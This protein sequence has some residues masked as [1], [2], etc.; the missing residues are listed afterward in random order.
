MFES[1]T[2]FEM[3]PL[4][5]LSE[6][7]LGQSPEKI[8]LPAFQRNAVWSE[9]KV[10]ALWDSLLCRFPIGSILL[11]RKNDFAEVGYREMQ[12]NRSSDY[13]ET[14]IGNDVDGLSII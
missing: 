2:P 1:G 3:V 11:A 12:V 7:L 4:S 10:E 13:P 9:E 6:D 8:G 5:K 14:K